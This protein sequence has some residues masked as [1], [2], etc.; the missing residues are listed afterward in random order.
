[1]AVSFH[2]LTVW[3]FDGPGKALPHRTEESAEGC[4]TIT[5]ARVI[6]SSRAS[7]LFMRFQEYVEVSA[8][9]VPESS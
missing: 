8:R 4:R 1:M 3:S 6:R 5:L 2:S 9:R 7:Q